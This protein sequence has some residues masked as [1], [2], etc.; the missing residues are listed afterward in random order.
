MLKLNDGTNR[1]ISDTIHVLPIC[2]AGDH[3][4]FGD[5]I[6]PKNTSFSSW[7]GSGP[8]TLGANR[9]IKYR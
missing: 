6:I 1:K 7:D 3:D 5:G 9:T 8:G 2:T 4:I